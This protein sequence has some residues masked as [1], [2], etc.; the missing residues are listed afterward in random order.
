MQGM[1]KDIQGRRIMSI[2]RIERAPNPLIIR[3]LPRFNRCSKR[4]S[5]AMD[6]VFHSL[7]LLFNK[8]ILLSIFS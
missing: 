2:E 4:Y 8:Q 1:R 5:K 3:Y 6:I 7:Y